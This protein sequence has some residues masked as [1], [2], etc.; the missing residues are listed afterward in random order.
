MV[1]GGNG[2]RWRGEKMLGDERQWQKK[3]RCMGRA[4]R[5]EEADTEGRGTEDRRHRTTRGREESGLVTQEAR[6]WT[7]RGR[8]TISCRR[9]H[10]K[11]GGRGEGWGWEVG[12][13]TNQDTRSS[14]EDSTG[15]SGVSV[16]AQE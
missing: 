15:P 2:E 1:L 6:G 9:G 5:G 11:R 14:L 12:A 3:K 7:Q 13:S 10:D 8:I 4:M 16:E